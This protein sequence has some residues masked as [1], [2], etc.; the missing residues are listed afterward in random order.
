[1]LKYLWWASVL[2]L[3]LLGA[4][5]HAEQTNDVAASY[6]PYTPGPDHVKNQTDF[7]KRYSQELG[8]T[9]YSFLDRF[10]VQTMSRWMWKA[11]R[12]G[13]NIHEEYNSQGRNAF[14]RAGLDSLRETAVDILPLDMWQNWA[15][16]L[17]RRSVGNTLEERTS[18]VSGEASAAETLWLFKQGLMRRSWIRDYGLR[19]FRTTP[20]AYISF[21]LGRQGD[22]PIAILDLRAEYKLFGKDR[23]GARLT[24]PFTENYHFVVGASVVPSRIDGDNGTAFSLRLQRMFMNRLFT[25]NDVPFFGFIG[26]HQ[27][28]HRGMVEIGLTKDW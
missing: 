28:R 26:Y 8:D 12:D 16:D 24:I 22:A 11:D 10:G 23:V 5:L 13:Y 21:N 18:M 14:T 1:M 6:I 4:N 9:S 7:W 25:E 2:T 19:P 20:Y 27:N 17:F 3:T 15:G